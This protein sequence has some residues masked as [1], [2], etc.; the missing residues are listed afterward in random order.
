M[1]RIIYKL[2]GEVDKST[3]QFPALLF[4]SRE[5]NKN[6]IIG[7]SPVIVS[8]NEYKVLKESKNGKDIA[9]VKDK[10]SLPKPMI[11]DING[12][13]K[14]VIADNFNEEQRVKELFSEKPKKV[15]KKKI[16]IKKNKGKKR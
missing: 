1:K 13:K 16:K 15:F 6:V 3:K 7:N 11:I 2:T 10:K 5:R 12:T 4:R 8:D 9:L 14:K